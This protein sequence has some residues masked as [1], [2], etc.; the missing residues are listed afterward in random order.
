MGIDV[1]N[2]LVSSHRSTVSTKSA[3]RGAAPPKGCTRITTIAENKVRRGIVVLLLIWAVPPVSRLETAQAPQQAPQQTVN[4]GDHWRFTSAGMQVEA[5]VIAKDIGVPSGM[6]FLPDG[7]ILA[8]DRRAGSL[9]LVD[10]R[11]GAKTTIEGLPAVHTGID[12]GTLDVTLHPRYRENGWLYVIYSV[13]L[14]GGSMAVIDRAKLSGTRLLSRT[15]IFEGRPIIENSE[16]YGARLLFHGGYLYVSLG[17][18]NARD[19]AQYL[20]DP[21]GKILRL[22]DD[23]TAAPNNP[24]ASRPDAMPEIWSYGH[25]NPQGIAFNPVTGALWE[26]EHGPRGG[27]EINI[28]RRGR[29]Y[30]W[31][32]VSFGTEYA[33]GPIGKGLTTRADVEPP[34]RHFTPAIGPSGMIFY[35][36]SKFPAWRNNMF[37]C[38]MVSKSL[39][40]FV[41]SGERIVQ[42]ER[43]LGERNWRLRNVV[44]GPDGFIYLGVD[45]GMLV[46]LSPAA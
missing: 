25:R 8:T 45:G 21:Y 3:C 39:L 23:G 16:H 33:G 43:L 14:P 31:P 11:T 27:D 32:L 44:Q 24:F 17:E 12:A 15:R 13:D 19:L 30:G 28:I 10:P 26:H 6:T 42:E 46:R 41:V 4:I 5:T 18:H 2:A 1:A 20:G 34:V 36:G 38:G 35:T 7:R 9:L 37:V 40:R 29:N 22:R